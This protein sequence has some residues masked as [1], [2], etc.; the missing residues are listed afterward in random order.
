MRA[1]SGSHLRFATHSTCGGRVSGPLFRAEKQPGMGNAVPK[2][3]LEN[4][5]AGC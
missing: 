1:R 4:S 5:S 3:D 2:A